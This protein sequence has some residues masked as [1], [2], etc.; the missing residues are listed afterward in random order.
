MYDGDRTN[1]YCGALIKGALTGL[2]S[3]RVFTFQGS[4]LARIKWVV[5]IPFIKWET[6]DSEG[7]VEKKADVVP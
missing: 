3:W 6:S 4:A 1:P 5:F 2:A 7:G